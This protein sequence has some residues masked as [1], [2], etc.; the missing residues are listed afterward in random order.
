MKSNFYLKQ[1]KNHIK[2]HFAYKIHRIL[3]YSKSNF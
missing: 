2:K 3:D 1:N